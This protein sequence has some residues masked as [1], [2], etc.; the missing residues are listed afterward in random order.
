MLASWSLLLVTLCSQSAVWPIQASQV[1]LD[2]GAL[3]PQDDKERLALSLARAVDGDF[4]GLAAL[5]A[6][7]PGMQP[8]ADVLERLDQQRRL[9][10]ES[11]VTRSRRMQ[12]WVDGEQVR[13]ELRAFEA[14]VVRFT[15]VGAQDAAKE[16]S[17][18]AD[19]VGAQEFASGSGLGAPKFEEASLDGTLQ[20]LCGDPRWTQAFDRKQEQQLALVAQW[21]ELEALL[22]LGRALHVLAQ[23]QQANSGQASAVHRL[24]IDRLIG[25]T[26]VFAQESRL[27]GRRAWWHELTRTEFEA[28][29]SQMPADELTCGSWTALPQDRARVLFDF[30]DPVCFE[31]FRA[32]SGP[33]EWIYG[34]EQAPAAAEPKREAGKRGLALL[35]ATGLRHGLELDPPCSMRLRYIL[36]L[37][38]SGLVG[39]MAAGFLDVSSERAIYAIG[40]DVLQIHDPRGP[41]DAQVQN[42]QPQPSTTD[43]LYELRLEHDGERIVSRASNGQEL[44]LAA[45]ELSG[46][47]F[48]VGVHTDHVIELVELELEGRA[49]PG[50]LASLR[51]AWAERSARQA[52]GSR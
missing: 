14:G 17:F 16:L 32:D 34:R 18:H 2:P 4:L 13:I 31:E 1:V 30:A 44:T 6:Q 48:A 3:Q 10:L 47:V 33:C 21:T 52:L 15:V 8:L 45:V 12:W 9:W 41:A 35:G 28:L 50:A 20:F 36:R 26:E 49:G 22:P 24:R 7:R 37:G 25:L 39:Y 40:R 51:S 19:E 42:R 29:A 43:V 5:L 46:C 23:T 11:A 38:Q 27:E